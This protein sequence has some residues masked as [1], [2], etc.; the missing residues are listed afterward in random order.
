MSKLSSFIESA[1]GPRH[2]KRRDIIVQAGLI[3]YWAVYA[4]VVSMLDIFMTM[5][6]D[7]ARFMDYMLVGGAYE[8]SQGE[9]A[10]FM[11]YSLMADLGLPKIFP[12]M[13][14]AFMCFLFSRR[15]KGMTGVIM[16]SV[17]MFP[18]FLQLR[19]IAK[20]AVWVFSALGLIFAFRWFR[21]DNARFVIITL[22]FV[23]L[24]L[25]FREYYLIS[26]GLIVL[27]YLGR[28][29]PLLALGIFIAAMIA[30]PYIAPDHVAELN[31]TR[32]SLSEYA[33][34]GNARSLMPIPDINW[35]VF[36]IYGYSFMTGIMMMFPVSVSLDYR[37]ILLQ[38]YL[39]LCFFAVR[40]ALRTNG[41]AA[42]TAFLSVFATLTLFVPDFGTALRHIGAQIPLLYLGLLYPTDEKKASGAGLFSSAMLPN[43]SRSSHLLK[44]EPSP[45]TPEVSS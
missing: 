45:Q 15:L 19:F 21:T 38:L 2:E 4:T 20:E 22:S 39:V 33:L 42:A 30:V 28:L 35:G 18:L 23:F 24:S 9:I 11:L 41:T 34:I 44:H 16:L 43:F 14:L 32:I 1:F 13:V 17:L 40:Q 12:M 10:T 29:K 25:V 6:F 5:G 36:T 7:E 26:A 8:Q 37:E 3:A 31:D 27:L